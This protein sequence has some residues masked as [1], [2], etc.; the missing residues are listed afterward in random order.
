MAEPRAMVDGVMIGPGHV[1][2]RSCVIF[3]SLKPP[4]SSSRND[5][6]VAGTGSYEHEIFLEK[7]TLCNVT[8]LSQLL[9]IFTFALH[10]HFFC[11]EQRRRRNRLLRLCIT[12]SETQGRMSILMSGKNNKQKNMMLKVESWVGTGTL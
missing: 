11:S 5:V 2:C 7:K 10:V 12:A 8:F 6:Y 4:P 3:V 1:I 9:R